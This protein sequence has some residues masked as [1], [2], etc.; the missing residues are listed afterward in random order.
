MKTVVANLKM[1]LIKE[2]IL[3]YNTKISNYINQNINLII[4]PT[5]IFLPLFNSKLNLGSQNVCLEEKGSFTGEVSAIQLTSLNVKYTLVGHSERRGNFNELDH[6]INK[7]IKV[8]LKNNIKVILCIGETKEEREENLTFN[9]IQREMINALTGI[10]DISNII[11][12]YEPI[13]AIGTGLN[14]DVNDIDEIAKFIR[15]FIKD[16]YQKSIDI[17]Y[18]G[19]VNNDNIDTIININSIDGVLIGGA[20]TNIDNFIKLLDKIG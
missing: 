20:S 10:N 12:A 6:D 16:E 7:K 11:I 8:S 5:S 14:A 17:L 3:E 4:C 2:E 19:S 13:W 15:R 18:G 1:N 9:V